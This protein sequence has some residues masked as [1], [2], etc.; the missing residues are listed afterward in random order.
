MFEAQYLFASDAV[1][2]PWMARQGT[3]CRLTLD[4]IK[5]TGSG[6]IV[7]LYQ[8]DQDD[9]GE[10]TAFPSVEIDTGS[11]GLTTTEFSPVKEMIRYR[12]STTGTGSQVAMFRMLSIAWFDSVRAS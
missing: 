6:F 5:L 1:Y 4:L 11:L 3:T 10:G 9:T 8:K 12:F 2:S 7:Q